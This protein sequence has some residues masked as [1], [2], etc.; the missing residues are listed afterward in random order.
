MAGFSQLSSDQPSW[1]NLRMTV[2]S[3]DS[4]VFL[5]S[6]LVADD[7]IS[8][9]TAIVDLLRG[10]KIHVA[11]GS[12]YRCRLTG[13]SATRG[14]A[15]FSQ[16]GRWGWLT[17]ISAGRADQVSQL[18]SVGTASFPN[19]ERPGL[20]GFSEEGWPVFPVG[21]WGQGGRVFPAERW[22]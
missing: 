9:R 5:S 20:A 12:D 14:L 13:R 2:P 15:G 16:L 7:W 1:N 6:P 21:R 22:G 17:R 4:L 8:R 3:S 19:L 18:G 11:Q 10:V